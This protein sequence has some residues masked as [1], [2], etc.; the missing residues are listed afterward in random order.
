MDDVDV[1]VPHARAA[2]AIETLSV[3][4]WTAES[5]DPLSRIEAHHSVNLAGPDGGNVDLHWFALWQPA[6][7]EPL[8]AASVPMEIAG[9]ATR[10][11]C[12]ADQLL[13]VCAHGVPWSRFPSFR[14][15]ADALVAVRRAGDALDWDRLAA[16][17]KRRRL[18]VAVAASLAFLREEF[19]APVPASL[20]LRLDAVPAARHERA[21]FHAAGRSESPVR[22]LELAWDRYRRLRDLDTGAPRPRSF[23]SFA[24][25][26]WGLDSARQL[27]LHAVRTICRRRGVARSTP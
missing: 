25:R 20:L 1:L 2:E 18:T 23:L 24:R 7:D 16:E 14:W 11:P 12:A 26:F 27:P 21:A 19:E 10:A 3:A 8:W 17:A 22:T 15:I 4:G 9:A 13:L 6:S 5:D